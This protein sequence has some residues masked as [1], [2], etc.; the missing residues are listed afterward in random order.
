M[1]SYRRDYSGPRR[2]DDPYRDTMKPPEP[3]R[4]PVCHAS[5][6]QG[7]WSWAPAP[8]DSH[9]VT[10]PA[11]LRIEDRFP[12]GYVSVKGKFLDDHRDE[13]IAVIKAKEMHQKS[14]HAL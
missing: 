1:R 5:F 13:I 3:T 6:T 14:E 2:T 4:C 11:C 8:P 9:Q 7:R 10:C 12:A